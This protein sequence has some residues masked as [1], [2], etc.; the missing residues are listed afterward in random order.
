MG[1]SKLLVGVVYNPPPVRDIGEL[2]S[3]VLSNSASFD[4]IIIV[5]DFNINLEVSTPP[6]ESLNDFLAATNLFIVPSAPTRHPWNGI[7]TPSLLDYYI[8]N[9][10]D[11]VVTFNQVHI[12]ISDHEF[13]TYNIRT[14]ITNTETFE[15]LDF[16]RVQLEKL[17]S[18]LV[19][20]NW[21]ELYNAN[22]IND[23]VALFN[24]VVVRAIDQFV[25]LR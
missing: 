10:L 3:F 21:S 19:N 2:G 5:G 17:D 1:G 9:R 22:N 24:G 6:N 14:P 13:M 12:P 18:F 25:P 20:H 16:T 11:K 23:K 15:F 8:T 7:G 4:D